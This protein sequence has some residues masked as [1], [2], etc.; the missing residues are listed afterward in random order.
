MDEFGYLGWHT[1]FWCKKELSGE[2][3]VYTDGEE[4]Y[5]QYIRDICGNLIKTYTRLADGSGKY[6]YYDITDSFVR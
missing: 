2:T 1:K 5:I 4:V 6:E 3:R